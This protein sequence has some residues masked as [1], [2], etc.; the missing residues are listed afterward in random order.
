MGH[1]ERMRRAEAKRKEEDQR[2]KAE[3]QDRQRL[4]EERARKVAAAAAAKPAAAAKRPAGGRQGKVR[5]GGG[6]DR[7]PGH[8]LGR[9]SAALR[10]A[11]TPG[12][13][14]SC[15]AAAAAAATQEDE[16]GPLMAEA[17]AA[18]GLP[19]PAAAGEA[20]REVAAGAAAAAR[21]LP[22]LASPA[23]QV[24]RLPSAA[25][26]PARR[27]LR[28]GSAGGSPPT[29]CCCCC[30]GGLRHASSAPAVGTP[31]PCLPCPALPGLAAPGLRQGRERKP[32]DAAPGPAAGRGP[33]AADPCCNRR[34][35]RSW[36]CKPRHQPARPLPPSQEAH[37]DT[38]RLTDQ[39]D[40]ASDGRGPTPA[41]HGRPLGRAPHRA[42]AQAAVQADG[43]R[44]AHPHGGRAHVRAGAPG[45]ATLGCPLASNQRCRRAL[46][47]LQASSGAWA[48]G[49]AAAA[50]G[51]P[52]GVP[53]NQTCPP[54]PL[55]PLRPTGQAQRGEAGVLALREPHAAQDAPGSQAQAARRRHH[56]RDL[57]LQVRPSPPP[58]PPR[59]LHAFSPRLTP[60]QPCR[61][62]PGPARWR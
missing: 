56:L 39:G 40:G 3:L 58:P 8:A 48:A 21:E 62:R 22:D 53:S 16:T 26:Q 59:P 13:D 43:R 18:A 33:A 36:C 54:L 50:C 31:P 24:R 7:M 20:A 45:A 38:P 61:C 51:R 29:C 5:A 42:A 47:E 41:G 35:G 46:L 37:P 49:A 25:L 23:V 6:S 52:P 34:A 57:A 60:C 27:R 17:A 32:Q 28:Q 19:R 10:R 9:G 1:E 2:R 12:Q 15:A 11:G 44:A 30:G 14:L 4:K 55:P